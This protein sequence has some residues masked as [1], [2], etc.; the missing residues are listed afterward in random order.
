MN[1]DQG[2]REIGPDGTITLFKDLLRRLGEAGHDLHIGE[3]ESRD[4]G[5]ITC[6]AVLFT[7]RHRY[8]LTAVQPPD[9]K[10]SRLWC[11]V[12]DRMASTN[13]LPQPIFAPERNI[14]Q[15]VGDELTADTFR[16]IVEAIVANELVVLDTGHE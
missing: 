8:G 14:L 7:A 15:D 9:G 10:A 6:T 12:R 11:F 1:E 13:P 16:R 4:N 2:Y 5:E 3:P